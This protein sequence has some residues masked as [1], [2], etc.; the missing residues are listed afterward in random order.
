LNALKDIT[1]AT[2]APTDP[3]VSDEKAVEREIGRRIREERIKRGM[4][5]AELAKRVG[6]TA[7]QGHK[8]ERGMNRIAASRLFRI[9]NIFGIDV[10]ALL[11]VTGTTAPETG[12]QLGLELARNFAQLTTE[13]QRLSVC[14]LVRSLAAGGEPADHIASPEADWDPGAASEMFR[15]RLFVSGTTPSSSRRSTRAVAAVRRLCEAHMPGRYTLEVV[16]IQRDPAAARENQIVAVPALLKVEPKPEQ[17][18]I[19]DLADASLAAWLG[20]S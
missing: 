4:T 12:D 18:F 11:P 5:Q 19:G 14:Q 2:L 7:Q 16:D 3:D 13:Q 10:S 17:V 8:Y 15:L 9:A 6:I 1:P 20:L